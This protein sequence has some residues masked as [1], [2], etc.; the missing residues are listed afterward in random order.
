MKTIFSPGDP[1][2]LV[3]DW[4]LDSECIAGAGDNANDHMVSTVPEGP[5][6]TTDP[7]LKPYGGPG[8]AYALESYDSAM[9][10]I[11]AIG[12]A[13]KANNGKLPNRPQ[14]VAAVA[15][16]RDLKGV[17][18]TWSFDANGDATN[19]VM[20]YYRVEPV[21]GATTPTFTKDVSWGPGGD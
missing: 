18:G 16:T 13:I 21:K 20:S 3:N 7:D 19:P 10:L 17:T 9:I 2:F 1:Y 6:T 12:R 5:T 14:V 11:D 8:R 15:A 4:V